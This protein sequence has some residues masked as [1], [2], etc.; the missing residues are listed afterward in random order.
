MAGPVSSVRRTVPVI[1]DT[2]AEQ[3]PLRILLAEDNLINQK[4]GVRLL[5]R[6][7]YHPD[8]VANAASAGRSSRCIGKLMTWS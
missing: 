4:V 3:L 1:D 7:G 2:L 8:V 5:Q 6:M